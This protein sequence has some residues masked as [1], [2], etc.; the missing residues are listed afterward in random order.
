MGLK[1]DK[2]VKI[3]KLSGC[4]N[5]LGERGVKSSP[6]ALQCIGMQPFSNS[7]DLSTISY[8]HKYFMTIS[9]TVHELSC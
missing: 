2:V 9:E 4:K 3:A 6:R 5:S 7:F 1:R 8:S